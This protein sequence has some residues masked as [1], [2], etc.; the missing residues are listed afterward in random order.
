MTTTITVDGTAL[1]FDWQAQQ[2]S[3]PADPQ[4]VFVLSDDMTTAAPPSA[5]GEEGGG[6][7]VV[8][9]TKT[10]STKK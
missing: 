5:G 1:P 6:D 8:L 2:E 10:R 9:T 7:P 3:N 4:P